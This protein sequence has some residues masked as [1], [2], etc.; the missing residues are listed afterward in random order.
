LLEVRQKLGAFFECRQSHRGPDP[1]AGRS[2][3]SSST[4]S[5]PCVSLHL[6]GGSPFAKSDGRIEMQRA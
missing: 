6:V 1:A 4:R 5:P 2:R 3:W